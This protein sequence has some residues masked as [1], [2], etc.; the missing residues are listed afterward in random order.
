M[1]NHI[2][3]EVVFPQFIYNCR[4]KALHT[5]YDT[6]QNAFCGLIH[7]VFLRWNGKFQ[8]N[9]RCH[10]KLQKLKCR[11]GMWNMSVNHSLIEKHNRIQ[12]FHRVQKNKDFISFY[13]IPFSL[14]LVLLFIPT[15]RRL[16]GDCYSHKY[17][18]PITHSTTDNPA[19][20]RSV[21]IAP[22]DSWS[23]LKSDWNLEVQKS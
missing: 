12:C 19:N 8:R 21:F 4:N 13:S 11:C 6:W 17:L 9:W 23:F 1:R 16:L 3:N 15:L 7:F 18:S 5:K 22:F 20:Y 10:F 2:P 14:N